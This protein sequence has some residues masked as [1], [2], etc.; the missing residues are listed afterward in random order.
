MNLKEGGVL[1]EEVIDVKE[2]KKKKPLSC[3]V[4]TLKEEETDREK[5][6]IFYLL[7]KMNK[8]EDIP[9]E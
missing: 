2:K 3:A 4:A 7:K 6:S 1:A 9:V 8:E 5:E